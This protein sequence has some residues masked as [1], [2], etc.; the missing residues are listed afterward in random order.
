MKIAPFTERWNDGERD[1][2]YVKDARQD[3]ERWEG[4]T[5][6]RLPAGYRDFMLRFNGGRV[7]PRMFHGPQ[8]PWPPGSARAPRP[9]VASYVDLIFDWACVESHWRGET[10]G[11]GV[12]PQHLVFADTPGPVQLLMALDAQHHGQIVTWHHSANA[13]G[14][15]GNDT[16][17]FQASDFGSFLKS[18]VDED[19]SDHDAWHLPIYDRLAREFEV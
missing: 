13:W 12:P 1:W 5:G 9:T 2:R 19:G 10:Y 8:A 15:D 7:Y 18:L 4:E 3:I 16:V 17:H 6:L 11:E 14:T